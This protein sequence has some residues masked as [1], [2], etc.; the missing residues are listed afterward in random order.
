MR[1]QPDPDYLEWWG[2][3]TPQE[4]WAR[5]MKLWDVYRS[6]TAGERRR[7]MRGDDTLL[8]GE[9]RWWMEHYLGRS[10]PDLRDA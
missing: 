3:L 1:F 7:L 2:G 4:R 8:R 9:F 5:S 6:L 10:M